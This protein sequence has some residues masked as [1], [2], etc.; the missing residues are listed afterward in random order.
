MAS[1]RFGRLDVL[2]SNAGIGP[3]SRLDELRVADWTR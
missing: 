1:A 3:I 2:V